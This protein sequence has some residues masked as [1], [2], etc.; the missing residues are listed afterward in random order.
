[1]VLLL[2][3]PL[4]AQEAKP[5]I[6]RVDDSVYRGEQPTRQD[7][8]KLASRGIRTVLDLRGALDHKAWEQQA[9]EAA[10]MRYIRVGLSGFFQPTEHQLD[11]I[12]ALLE[13]PTLGPIFVHCRRGADR[14]GLV[15]ACYRISHD[16]WT[17]AEAMQEARQHGFSRLEVLMQRYI[18]HFK[19]ASPANEGGPR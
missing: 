15:I 19:P 14:S 16:H 7:I 10:G 11:T 13:S 1:L 3:F 2:A 17:N 12:L 4:S 5:R 18:Q 9:V 6:Y 8:P